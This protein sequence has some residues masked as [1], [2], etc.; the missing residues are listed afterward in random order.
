VWNALFAQIESGTEIQ[1]NDIF[2]FLVWELGN[3][4]DE[5][6]TCLYLKNYQH[7]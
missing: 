1:T 3:A 2:P 7:Y 4:A 5:L 6:H